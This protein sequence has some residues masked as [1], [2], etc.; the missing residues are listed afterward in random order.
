MTQETSSG[1]TSITTR[2]NR[3]PSFDAAPVRDARRFLDA[4]AVSLG[5]AR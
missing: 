2:R 4:F 3:R 1:T 5:D